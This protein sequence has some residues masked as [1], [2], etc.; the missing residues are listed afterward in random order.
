[1]KMQ[2]CKIALV[3]SCPKKGTT[4]PFADSFYFNIK[5]N[6]N[7][8]SIDYDFCSVHSVLSSYPG[9]VPT[10]KEFNWEAYSDDTTRLELELADSSPDI[11]IP[12]G[13]LALQYF[14][15]DCGSLDDERGAPFLDHQN[16]LCLAT[17]HP[18]DLFARHHLTVL[19][20][21]DL[22]K[23]RRLGE[24]GWEA[25][26][27]NINF[28]PTF[29]AV[30]SMLQQFIYRKTYLSVDIETEYTT[31]VMTCIGFAYSEKDAL[32]IPFVGKNGSGRYWSQDEEIA[33]FQLIS[34]CL[35]ACPCV[36]HNA[37]HFDY[38]QLAKVHGIQANFID[39]TMFAQW[40]LF[41]ELSKSLSFCS[42]I[43]TDNPYWKNELKDARRGKI[44]RWK[45]FEYN[46]RDCIICMQCAVAIGKEIRERRPGVREHY[47]F[48]VRVSRAY[49]YMAMMG[50]RID[51]DK[52][53]HRLHELDVQAV[54]MQDQINSIVGRDIN[55]RS[56]KQMKHYLYKEL[57]L[58]ERTKQIKNPDGSTDDRVTADY[59]TILYLAREFQDAPGLLMMGTLR[60]LQKRISSLNKIKW[61][62]RSIVRWGFNVVGTETGR[63]SGYKPLDGKGV[64]PQN[65]DRR[66]RDLFMPLEGYHWC[67]ADLEGA[68]SVTVAACLE[69]AGDKR[70]H[71][72]IKAGLK[73]AQTLALAMILGNE[74]MQWSVDKIKAH[75]FKLKE[76]E[77]KNYYK[78]AKAINHG[79]AYMLSPGGMHTNI[80]R[81]SDG[82]LFVTPKECEKNQQLLFRRYDYPTYHRQ[83]KSVMHSARTL[84]A[85]SGQE[86]E[87]L[88]RPDN[89]TLRKMLAY[90]PQAHTAYVTNKTIE[91]LYYSE[92]NRAGEGLL[93]KLCN[94]VHDETDFY[95]PI[96]KEELAHEIFYSLCHVPIELWGCKFEIK[97]EA[98]YGANWGDCQY[99]L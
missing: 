42:S 31:G 93:L 53:K 62:E 36:G 98:N 23:A 57:G 39:D 48:N 45:E 4:V 2:E 6:C 90:L 63:S 7:A 66:D 51:Q 16:R 25:P 71:E 12:V 28:L 76:D 15:R 73:P 29:S 13:A 35:A 47:K 46:G 55:V 5:Q 79:S 50:A 22:G 3:A 33:L 88:G 17:Y 41:P 92:C 74:V 32:V 8:A 14:K 91:A 10:G 87:F 11:I 61:D 69:V 26:Q 95:I 82:D 84:V 52:L 72:D 37:C 21:H 40:E 65:V 64:Q 77:Y 96:G 30:K 20:Q 81:L 38:E 56:S 85:A 27:Y 89:S 19:A 67:K 68:D 75:L 54:A 44:P 83:I 59:L 78:I 70:L 18:I 34:R 94:Q 60:K 99:T 80:F 24:N 43:Y 97:F 49:E 58:P 86:R 9:F 1:M